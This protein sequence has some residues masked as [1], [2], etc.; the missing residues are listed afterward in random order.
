VFEV[1]K[2]PLTFNEFYRITACVARV[3]PTP[4][5]ARTGTTPQPASLPASQLTARRRVLRF[6][7]PCAV[8]VLRLLVCVGT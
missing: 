1:G 8:S 5:Y 3:P 2:G 7:Q 6:S 4:E